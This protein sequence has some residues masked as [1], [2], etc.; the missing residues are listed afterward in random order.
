MLVL[1]RAAEFS[2]VFRHFL[3]METCGRMVTDFGGRP[4]L[5]GIIPHAGGA[6]FIDVSE[7]GNPLV[8]PPAVNCRMAWVYKQPLWHYQVHNSRFCW[9][10]EDEWREWFEKLR[11]LETPPDVMA[12]DAA[13]WLV[14]AMGYVLSR[15]WTGFEFGMVDWHPSWEDYSHGHDGVREY[16]KGTFRKS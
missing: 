10:L 12:M 4:C 1:E 8:I 11:K 2:R 15:H 3:M 6:S 7:F 9:V 14:G 16:Q 5:L 13:A